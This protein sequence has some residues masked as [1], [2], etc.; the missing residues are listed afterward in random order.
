MIKIISLQILFLIPLFGFSQ[1]TSIPDTNF[2]KALIEL[3][4]DDIID[5][6]VLSNKIKSVKALDISWKEIADLTGIQDFDSLQFL[7]CAANPFTALDVSNN[8]ALKGLDLD[9]EGDYP[10]RLTNLDLSKNI[11]LTF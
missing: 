6:R 7:F 3:G 8:T 4:V 9:A 2:E 1:Y 5:G 10:C 11:Q